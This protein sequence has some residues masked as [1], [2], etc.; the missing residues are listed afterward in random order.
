[1]GGLIDQFTLAAGDFVIIASENNRELFAAYGQVLGVSPFRTLANAAGHIS[2]EDPWGNILDSLSYSL[3][4]YG[5]P[6]K[7]TGG[8]SLERIN[9]FRECSDAANWRASVS[10]QGASPGTKNSVYDESP[11]TSPF[12]I[13]RVLS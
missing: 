9:P 10:T 2:I 13:E 1:N 12:Y 6:Q 8:W 4:W 11:D 7:T 5:D 3:D